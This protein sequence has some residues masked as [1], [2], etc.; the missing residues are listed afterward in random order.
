L[1]Q[2]FCPGFKRARF[3]EV[4][5]IGGGCHIRLTETLALALELGRRIK[6]GRR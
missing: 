6:E 1:R 2:A 5:E 3:Y 4:I